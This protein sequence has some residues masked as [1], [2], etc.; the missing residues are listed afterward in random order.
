MSKALDAIQ[1]EI[2]Q[3]L[4]REQLA[5]EEKAKHEAELARMQ[6]EYARKFLELPKVSGGGLSS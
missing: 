6:V 4:R 2:A 1:L 5:K 3:S